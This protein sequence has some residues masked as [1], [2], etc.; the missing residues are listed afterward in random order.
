MQS[1]PYG[2]SW[3]SGEYEDHIAI[4]LAILLAIFAWKCSSG[5]IIELLS[6]RGAWEYKYLFHM[7]VKDVTERR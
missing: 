6:T 5:M 1:A 4:L 3:R 7:G 2:L